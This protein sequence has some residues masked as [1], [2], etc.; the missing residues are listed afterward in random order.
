[1]PLYE[2]FMCVHFGFTVEAGHC[3]L[4]AVMFTAFVDQY[5]NVF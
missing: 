1:M 5:Y 3:V 4:H 2:L